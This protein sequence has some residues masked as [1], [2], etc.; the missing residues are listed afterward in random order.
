[1]PMDTDKKKLAL[2]VCPHCEQ[3]VPKTKY[4]V[5]C[6][7]EIVST[8][9]DDTHQDTAKILCKN[10]QKTVPTLPFCINCGQA[11]NEIVEIEKNNVLYV[12]KRSQF[13][14]TLS[15]I[16]VGHN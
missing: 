15:V 16:Y 1:M 12:V 2:I 14:I 7:G 9:D 3:E 11:L 5:T 6:G 4:C 10:C 8:P 13:L